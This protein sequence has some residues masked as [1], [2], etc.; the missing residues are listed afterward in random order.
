[1]NYR[2][3]EALYWIGRLGSFHSAARHLQTSQAAISTR[4]RDLER[5]LGVA[6]FDRTRN[7]VL[8]TSK[9]VELMPYAAQLIALAADV[10]RVGVGTAMAGRVR[11]GATSIHALTWLPMLLRNILI[12][13][14]G[15]TIDLAIDTSETLQ[16]MIEQGRLEIAVLA[17]PVD[18]PR[19]TTEPVGPI[20]NVWVASPGLG[21]QRGPWS[22]RELAR[23]PII[24]DR[25]GS[26][27]HAAA[28]AW[29]RVEGVEPVRHHSASHL[30][31]RLHLAEAGVG[32]ALAAN[33][34]AMR[35]VRQGALVVIETIRR[36]PQLDYILACADTAL[37]PASHRVVQLA[38][39]IIREKPDL[40]SYFAAAS[41]TG[42]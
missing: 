26:R 22:A 10:Q 35:Y 34:A 29:F 30:Q 32:I 19:L 18:S 1:M 25:S 11:F 2:H 4:I 13:A 40:D 27:L 24:S 33:S 38:T 21:L 36:P 3:Y 17:G 6:L 23:H 5:Q 31:A 9:G 37:S 42:R 20:P 12:E 39:A 14:P 8:P 41:I 16:T 28:L 15:I 7:G